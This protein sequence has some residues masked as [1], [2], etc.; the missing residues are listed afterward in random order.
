MNALVVEECFLQGEFLRSNLLPGHILSAVRQEVSQSNS[1]VTR[2]HRLLQHL[3][4]HITAPE[5]LQALLRVL[6]ILEHAYIRWTCLYFSR[7]SLL[8]M[9]LP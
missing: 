1:E 4:I 6:F 8:V 5:Q 3:C 2:V 7:P 9:V